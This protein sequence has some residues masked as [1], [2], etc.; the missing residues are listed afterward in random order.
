VIIRSSNK[1]SGS[2]ISKDADGGASITTPRCAIAAYG[3]LV[4]ER[5]TIPPCGPGSTG[6]FKELAVPAS[7]Q[8]R[9][10]SNKAGASH[11]KLD[12]NHEAAAHHCAHPAPLSMSVLLPGSSNR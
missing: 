12:R 6:L 3:F 5:E 1:K 7:Y 2:D 11:P 9:G 10:A 8:P 4:S